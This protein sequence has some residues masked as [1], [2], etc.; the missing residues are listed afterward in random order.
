MLNLYVINL[1]PF[2]FILLKQNI[3]MLHWLMQNMS[4]GK[5]LTLLIEFIDDLA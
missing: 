5:S 2:D 1:R 3:K 4:I